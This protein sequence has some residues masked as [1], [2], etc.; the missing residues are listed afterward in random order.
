MDLAFGAY[1]IFGIGCII[2]F[3]LLRKQAGKY[4]LLTAFGE[5][6]YAKWRGLYNFLNS[7]TLMNERSYVEVGLWEKYLIYAS[8]FGIAEKVSDAIGLRCPEL[9]VEASPVLR[10]GSYRHS[11]FHSSSRSVHSSV[12]SSGSFGGGG[13]GGF[14]YGGGGRGGGGGGGGH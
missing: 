9:A 2:A 3:A 12:R 5:E 13:G 4:V 7:E 14:G 10:N 1:F 8:A 11:N 6:E